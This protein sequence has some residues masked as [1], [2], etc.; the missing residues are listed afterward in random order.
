MTQDDTN[1]VRKSQTPP[2]PTVLSINICDNIIRDESTKK[3]SLIGLFSVIKASG[4]P[5][6]HPLMQIYIALTNGH[7]KYKTEIRFTRLED[8]KPIAGMVGELQFQNP[9][10]VLE[11][12]LC[13]QQ[14]PLEKA[15]EYAV[16]VLCNDKQVGDRK[17][18]V[19]GPQVQMPPTYGT[20]VR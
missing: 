13:W 1:K 4:F 20:E 15:G 3:V 9:L 14:L 12:N 10:Q 2:E 6:S 8:N 11:L 16:E 5:C 7:G 19:I 18:M 17:F